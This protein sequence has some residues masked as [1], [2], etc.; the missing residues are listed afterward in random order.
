MTTSE[1]PVLLRSSRMAK[2]DVPRLTC[3]APFTKTDRHRL[4]QGCEVS[5]LVLPGIGG[6]LPYALLVD[7]FVQV[8]YS[9]GSRSHIRGHDSYVSGYL[10]LSS[11][12]TSL[13]HSA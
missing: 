5:F 3:S 8:W 2:I 11:R 12:V 7:T 4:N 10:F 13:S 9:Q 6:F 1:E